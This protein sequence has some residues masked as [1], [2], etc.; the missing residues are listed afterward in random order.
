L[1]EF[2][3]GRNASQ[4]FSE[5]DRKTIANIT[6]RI[7]NVYGADKNTSFPV[8]SAQNCSDMIVQVGEL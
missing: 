4:P 7:I 2:F 5:N 1:E 3:D 6:A 8:Q